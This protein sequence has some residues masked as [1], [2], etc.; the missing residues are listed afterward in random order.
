MDI[1]IIIPVFNASDFIDQT[2]MSL[3]SQKELG[4]LKVEVILYND[5]STDD[6]MSCIREFI[7]MQDTKFSW[8]IRENDR[9][10]GQGYTRNRA[11]E[12]SQGET[13]L[14][15]D[16]DDW[17][18]EKALSKVWRAYNESDKP[19]MVQFEWAYYNALTGKQSYVE[20]SNLSGREV[21]EGDE[22][23]KLLANKTYFSV[24]KLYKKEFIDKAVIEYGE[25][26]IYEDFEFFVKSINRAGKIVCLPNILYLVR[27]HENSTTKTNHNTTK[28]Y[29]S[30]VIAT[31]KTMEILEPRTSETRFYVLRYFLDRS[32]KYGI[33]VPGEYK[34]KLISHVQS[35]IVKYEDEIRIP[36]NETKLFKRLVSKTLKTKGKASLKFDYKAINYGY[37][38]A[39]KV[40][41]QLLPLEVPVVKRRVYKLV[42]KIAMKVLPKPAKYLG[43]TVMLGFDFK[44]KGN[45]KYLFEYLVEHEPDAPLYFA[46]WDK[47]VPDKYR[48]KPFSRQFYQ[49]LSS[50][51]VVVSE[52][53]V[54]LDIKKYPNQEWIQLWHGT[55]LK[56]MLFDSFEVD[57]VSKAPTHK[58]AKMADIQ[59][60]D[61]FL[62]D[63]PIAVDKFKSSML[64]PDKKYLKYGY[65]RNEWLIN[66]VADKE[67]VK[68]ILYVP[69]W[70]DYNHRIDASKQ[71]FAYFLN[72]EKLS[73][74][75]GEGYEIHV[76]DH[77]L[78]VGN[79]ASSELRLVTHGK[80]SDIQELI[81]QVDYVITDYSSVLFDCLH[82]ET[83]FYLYVKDFD[84][85]SQSRGVYEDIYADF[86]T[87][88]TDEVEQLAEMIRDEVTLSLSDEY[89]LYTA[90]PN[91]LL[92]QKIN[93][94]SK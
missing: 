75:L 67:G 94:L 13:I 65:P 32:F 17:L 33:R 82:I 45:S 27:V 11:L 50:A 10:S 68:K 7:E 6:S 16:S 30:F 18:E 42:N 38:V 23:D 2:L 20:I 88:T 19:D 43:G 46:S 12:I 21:L 60:W 58:K 1:S 72:L 44:L 3:T 26:Y 78:V 31:N 25:G 91:E 22:C 63:A 59:R 57:I 89:K 5:E 41:S 62:L 14:F 87:V 52:S 71:D 4:S 83:P 76:K 48:L 84:K 34:S 9:N 36:T 47:A 55:P 51:K 28:H 61:Y 93:D 64:I 85:F 80:E 86:S 35:L 70:R 29:D 53:W 66:N 37:K 90:T 69:T 81:A 56:K 73:N 39:N 74:L 24:N 8:V 79:T 15:L 92:L 40:K 54:P 77:D 49:A